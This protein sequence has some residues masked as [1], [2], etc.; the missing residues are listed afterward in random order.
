M[1]SVEAVINLYRASVAGNAMVQDEMMDLKRSSVLEAF[2]VVT[3][4]QWLV[5]ELHIDLGWLVYR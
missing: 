5:G 2:L 1:T 4:D 3:I